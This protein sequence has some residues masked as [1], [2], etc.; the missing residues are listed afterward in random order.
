MS[1]WQQI[2][3]LTSTVNTG[4]T[5]I[6]DRKLKKDASV[7][8][9]DSWSS[10]VLQNAN[11]LSEAQRHVEV[12]ID[13]QTGT[14]APIMKLPDNHPDADNQNIPF[15]QYMLGKFDASAESM[16]GNIKNSYAKS[17]LQQRSLNYKN[18][19]AHQLAG[20][21]ANIIMDKRQ[22]MAIESIEKLAKATYL[23]PE[24]YNKHKEDALIS[25]ESLSTS[26]T[27]KDKLARKAIHEIALGA[28]NSFLRA[29]PQS[30]LDE[31]TQHNWKADLDQYSIQKIERQALA[32]INQQQNI[33]KHKLQT[34][35]KTH[36]Q[37]ILD[38]G[39][40]IDGIEDVA[41][42]A[43]AGD[44]EAINAFI[45]K[46]E[47]YRKAHT[48]LQEAKYIP[49]LQAQEVADALYP[50]E[51]SKTYLEEKA[52]YKTVKHQI[53]KWNEL[54]RKDPA[55]F[56][57][58]LFPEQLP[59]DIPVG[60]KFQIRKNLQYQKGIPKHQRRYLTNDEAE[61]FTST[62]ESGDPVKIQQELDRIAAIEHEHDPIGNK[63]ID[64][65]LNNKKMSSLLHFYADSYLYKRDHL[66][67]DLA[68]AIASSGQLFGEF[69]K[70]DKNAI[71]KEIKNNRSVQDWEK[72]MLSGQMDNAEEVDLMK[73]GLLNLSRFYMRDKQIDT[74]DA[75]ELAVENLLKESYINL[76]S[77]SLGDL[78]V[79]SSILDEG[80]VQIL[81]KD[82]LT[83][84]IKRLRADIINHKLDYNKQE[85]F[86]VDDAKAGRVT[87]ALRTGRF[88]LT[89]DKKSL[90]Y[91]FLYQEQENILRDELS[92]PVLFPLMALNVPIPPNNWLIDINLYEHE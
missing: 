49:I 75:T 57:E 45:K 48:I 35:S 15:A 51:V 23:S 24:L 16:L 3:S 76:S 65:L 80:D 68:K 88:R 25:I 67:N 36:F 28:A 72:S 7:I 47:L 62:L 46:E 20:F 71:K 52:L 85:S 89:P 13:Q 61:H 43:F 26:P 42:Q 73:V 30:I 74:S 82:N 39:K 33:Y 19:L 40:G 4:L 55:K 77:W 12:D 1:K 32:A 69:S 2:A 5:E 9:G 29:S 27:Q 17:L 8:L 14:F 90:Y 56:V 21:E 87:K 64:E 91:V 38:N 22:S 79:P 53:A 70:D 66:K 41:E 18:Q 11:D 84:N 34:I 37:S 78:H 83:Y 58:T 63:I 44:Q 81:D 6:W 10:F 60:E 86:G 59:V 92:Q 31:N 50:Q 54:A